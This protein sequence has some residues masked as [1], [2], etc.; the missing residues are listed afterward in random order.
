CDDGDAI[1]VLPLPTATC[2]VPSLRKS[3]TDPGTSP[4]R[5]RSMANKL[6]SDFLHKGRIV[7]L[8]QFFEERTQPSS[9]F[10]FHSNS[11][12]TEFRHFGSFRSEKSPDDSEIIKDG[13]VHFKVRAS[14]SKKVGYYRSWRQGW[15]QIRRSGC[16]YLSKERIT[17][18]SISGMEENAAILCVGLKDG[19]SIDPAEDYSKRKHVIR[20]KTCSS[21]SNSPSGGATGSSSTTIVPVQANVTLI[22]SPHA[23]A[24]T[25]S[26]NPSLLSQVEILLQAEDPSEMSSWLKA[27]QQQQDNNNYYNSA[28]NSNSKSNN[29]ASASNTSATNELVTPKSSILKSISSGF[30]SVSSSSTTLANNH[31]LTVN[32]QHL[33][34]PNPTSP[35]SKTWKSKVAKQLQKMHIPS[36]SSRSNSTSGYNPQGTIPESGATFGVHLEDCPV[37]EANP[38]VPRV[39]EFCINTI[40]TRGL[41]M[42]GIYRIPG[43]NA[44]VAALMD[45]LNKGNE[46]NPDQ[47]SRWNDVH[48]ISSMLKSFLRNLP[49]PL[50]TSDKYEDFIRVVST[51]TDVQLQLERIKALIDSLPDINYETLRYLTLHL[52]KVS[53]N[54]EKNRMES[55]N[56][57]IVFGPTLVRPGENSA[58]NMVQHMSFQCKLVELLINNAYEF[59]PSRDQDQ[60]SPPVEPP[61]S[62]GSQAATPVAVIPDPVAKFE[63]DIRTS[64]IQAAQRKV[65]RQQLQPVHNTYGLPLAPAPLKSNERAIDES[66]LIRSYAG[67]GA[68]TEQRV[69]QF[70]L[71]TRAMLTRD[72]RSPNPN[73][74]AFVAAS[75]PTTITSSIPSKPVG[76]QGISPQSN[77]PEEERRL[78]K[79]RLEAEWR[80]AK[81]D[82]EN[83]DFYD[84]LADNPSSIVHHREHGLPPFALL[85]HNVSSSSVSSSNSAG[86]TTADGSEVPG[87]LSPNTTWPMKLGPTPFKPYSPSSTT[88]LL[89]Q[90][91]SSSPVSIP[92]LPP[93]PPYANV[94]TSSSVSSSSSTKMTKTLVVTPP[95]HPPHLNILGNPLRKVSSVE[96]L[97][98]PKLR[99]QQQQGYH[100]LPASTSSGDRFDHSKVTGRETLKRLKK[101]ENQTAT[102][103]DPK[104]CGSLDSL[105]D[106]VNGG[107]REDVSLRSSNGSDLVAAMSREYEEKL[108]ALR[109]SLHLQKDEK[110][111]QDEE[112][113][114]EANNNINGGNGKED[115][116]PI[117]EED[118]KSREK[119]WLK[120]MEGEITS[121]TDVPNLKDT[122]P[123]VQSNGFVLSAT[124]KGRSKS[125]IDR[126]RPSLE[127]MEGFDKNSESHGNKLAS[128]R[129]PSL[130]RVTNNSG[131]NDDSS[132]WVSSPAGEE[133]EE[134][135]LSPESQHGLSSHQH[136]Y[137]ESSTSLSKEAKTASNNRITKES[138]RRHSLSGTA[139]ILRFMYEDHHAH[140]H[141]NL[142]NRLTTVSSS[143]H[144]PP[145]NVKN[146]SND[147]LATALAANNIL[148][149]HV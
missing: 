99:Q 28:N 79:L 134:A 143:T 82:L 63:S 101:P 126:R 109:P 105:R 33:G 96:Q 69:R 14:E 29:N 128:Y 22:T 145:G 110:E 45:S 93:K 53:E 24:S 13:P 84:Q 36:G 30:Q 19:I 140:H 94:N 135:S 81:D 39:L 73:N 144:H 7:R 77:Q 67:L 5:R 137:R 21:N 65:S 118:N 8:K 100:Q 38:S 6:S 148:E 86:G 1:V 48:V 116:N 59:F 18:D 71:E 80:K 49:D 90:Q 97:V 17:K 26:Q 37:T 133:G 60:P 46:P 111:H 12:T 112:E 51:E 146:L 58:A 32:Q 104:L 66:G 103:Y 64:L 130:H 62:A 42:V 123:S 68:E 95:P 34:G 61:E 40:E 11:P 147:A 44:A 55:K 72:G 149:S 129:D 106:I 138:K 9:L 102:P 119:I 57:S 136:H 127:V 52:R 107:S 43:N 41:T 4:G 83:E 31:H 98:L 132:S 88:T 23:S 76:Q 91:H 89:S 121:T 124:P 25:D 139:D 16:L 131:G 75:V 141:K 108:E 35:K 47:D 115:S 87:A 92:S 15:A 142:T 3:T 74:S 56:L 20:L 50:L 113:E 78:E 122:I 2:T 27:L 114:A 10:K 120:K 85:S 117:E 54:S 125:M 70:E